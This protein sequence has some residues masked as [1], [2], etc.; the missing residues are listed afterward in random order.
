M[1][2]S[3]VVATN[4]GRSAL[5]RLAEETHRLK[6]DD[7]LAPVV[8]IVPNNI[9]G[10]VARRALAGATDGD[11]RGVAGLF[12]ATLPRLA[13]QLAASTL[14]P[15]RPATRPLVAAAWRS[16]LAT[17]HGPFELVGEHPATVKALTATHRELRDLSESALE[18]VAARGELQSALVDLHRQVRAALAPLFYDETD[19]LAA[20]TDLI[21]TGRATPDGP[22]VLYLPGRLTNAETAFAQ[23]IAQ[24]SGI[25]VIAGFTGDERAD[26]ATTEILHRLGANAPD[27]PDDVPMAGEI[28]H[29]SDSDDEVRAVVRELVNASERHTRPPD[30]RPV[31]RRQPLRPPLARTARGSR[32]RVQRAG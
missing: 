13:E 32:A 26:S 17:H 14:V 15:R 27:R 30:R 6:G 8:V 9:A 29:A 4:Y 25:T 24:L 19:L 2:E 7:P 22:V 10:I 20:A 3:T 18:E 31:L 23:T 16:V 21:A 11:R 5:E 28:R 12:V 1:R